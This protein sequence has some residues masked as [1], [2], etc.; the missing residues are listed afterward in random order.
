VTEVPTWEELAVSGGQLVT[1]VT[2]VVAIPTLV[3]PAGQTAAYRCT[4]F[5]YSTSQ[6]TWGSF[7]DSATIAAFRLSPTPM[8]IYGSFTW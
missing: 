7:S 1:T 5:A 6:R 2:V 4:L 3:N 8:T